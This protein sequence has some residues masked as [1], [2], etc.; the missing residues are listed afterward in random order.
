M[1]ERHPYRLWIASSGFLIA[2]GGASGSRMTGKCKSSHCQ[3]LAEV[4]IHPLAVGQG[5]PSGLGPAG[6]VRYTPGNCSAG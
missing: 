3:C 5:R 1:N 4:R 2:S 6:T